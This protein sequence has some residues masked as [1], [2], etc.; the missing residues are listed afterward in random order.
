MTQWPSNVPDKQNLLKN[1][2]F[3]LRQRRVVILMLME[4]VEKTANM[5]IFLSSLAE[6]LWYTIAQMAQAL[7]PQCQWCAT[8]QGHSIIPSLFAI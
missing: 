3:F 5:E 1:L 2:F 7:P 4:F 8:H 6:I